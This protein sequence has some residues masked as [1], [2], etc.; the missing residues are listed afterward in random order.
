MSEPPVPDAPCPTPPGLDALHRLVA[1]AGTDTGQARPVADFLLAWWNARACG[2][3]DL[4][5]LWSVAPPIRDDMLAVLALIA[6]HREFPDAY[7]LGDA[8]EALVASW[9]PGVAQAHR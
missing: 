2:G 9:R 5:A 7:G 8:F 4:T 6:H 3:F 1:I